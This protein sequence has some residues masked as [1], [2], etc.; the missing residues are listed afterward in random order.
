MD[1]EHFEMEVGSAFIKFMP[2]EIM[3]RNKGSVT[4][5][6]YYIHPDHRISF[7]G[8]NE[9][10]SFKRTGDTKR[11]L[12]IGMD[13]MK[14]KTTAWKVLEFIREAGEEG[15]SLQEI[16]KFIYFD[17]NGAPLGHSWFYEKDPWHGT[18]RSR[19]Y[20]NTALYSSPPNGNYYGILKAWC[21]KN[22]RRKWVIRR[23]PRKGENLFP[24][25]FPG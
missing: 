19:G 15:R 10:V 25:E 12:D 2:D 1:F 14:L 20:W 13:P 24:V 5:D 16:Q 8:M 3:V 21:K 4:R 11:S 22:D 17:I 7:V 18:R 6:W 9:G 23:M